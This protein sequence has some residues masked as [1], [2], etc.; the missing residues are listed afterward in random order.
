MGKR[1]ERSKSQNRFQNVCFSFRLYDFEVVDLNSD[2]S[3]LI[4][5]PPVET[6]CSVPGQKD[7]LLDRGDLMSISLQVFEMI[8]LG[9]YQPDVISR[10][11]R[12]SCILELDLILAQHSHREVSRRFFEC[13]GLATR[14]KL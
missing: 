7:S 1:L 11:S 9:T 4:I 3:F 8:H 2:V 12:L 13:Q 10:Y 6:S 5:V 14:E